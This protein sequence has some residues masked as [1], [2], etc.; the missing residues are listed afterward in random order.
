MSEVKTNVGSAKTPEKVRGLPIGFNSV[1][2][3][4]I[5]AALVV[6]F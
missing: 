4:G 6:I 2:I 3:I 1:F 5:L